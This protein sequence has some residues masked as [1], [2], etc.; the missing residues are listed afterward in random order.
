MWIAKVE[1]YYF[2][3]AFLFVYFLYFLFFQPPFIHHH[4]LSLLLSSLSLCSNRVVPFILYSF[5]CFVLARCLCGWCDFLYIAHRCLRFSL[6]VF[7]L[8]CVFYWLFRW[9][10]NKRTRKNAILFEIFINYSRYYQIVLT[11]N[12]IPSSVCFCTLLPLILSHFPPP[13]LLSFTF[14]DYCCVLGFAFWSVASWIHTH[15]HI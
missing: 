10:P 11:K 3:S 15:K 1:V 2:L 5:V 13:S 4:A 8:W 7:L 6:S 12:L 14:I 9:L